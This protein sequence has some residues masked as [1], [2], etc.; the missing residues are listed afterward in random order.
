VIVF[1][2]WYDAL[3]AIVGLGAPMLLIEGGESVGKTPFAR[4]VAEQTGAL[5]LQSD[6]FTRRRRAEEAYT[7]LVDKDALSAAAAAARAPVIVEGVCLRAVLP[8]VLF[9]SS[10]TL[11]VRR[12]STMGIWHLEHNVRLLACDNVLPWLEREVLQYHCDYSPQSKCTHML[13]LIEGDSG[14]IQSIL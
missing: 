6:C 3:D 8:E 4:A 7:D 11:Y 2:R 12:V 14:E 9:V 1:E 5:V 13:T 10:P